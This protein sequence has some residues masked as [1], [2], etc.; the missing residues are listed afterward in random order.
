MK[1]RTQSR[2]IAVS[3][4]ACLLLFLLTAAAH[5]QT[6]TFTHR[7]GRTLEAELTGVQAGT[8]ALKLA[9]GR[10]AGVPIGDLSEADQEFIR[11]WQQANP[12][13]RIEIS[14]TRERKERTGDSSRSRERWVYKITVTNRSNAAMPAGLILHYLQLVESTNRLASAGDRTRISRYHLGTI[15]LPEI[16][17]LGSHSIETEPMLTESVNLSTG[18]RGYSERWSEN[19]SALNVEI[20][21]GDKAV[22]RHNQGSHANLGVQRSDQLAEL[23]RDRLRGRFDRR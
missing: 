17:P 22:A 4:A 11:L 2:S 1:T 6:R 5:A 16:E 10:T 20:R 8:A 18:R 23:D 13:F 21:H 7:D 9:G 15:T 14:T 3:L 19:L 12:D